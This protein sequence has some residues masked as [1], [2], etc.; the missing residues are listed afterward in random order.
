ML[1]ERDLTSLI[2]HPRLPQCQLS[3]IG[4]I[5]RLPELLVQRIANRFKFLDTSI[6]Q[7]ERPLRGL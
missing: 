3:G 1:V 7:I 4:A 6:R 2:E 5:V